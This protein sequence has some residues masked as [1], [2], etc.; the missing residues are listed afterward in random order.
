[1]K[2][3]IFLFFFAPLLCFAQYDFDSRYFTIDENSLPASEA[4]SGFKKESEIISRFSL[5]A[6]PVVV[7]EKLPSFKITTNNYRKPV[8]MAVAINELN[9]FAV[10]S[11]ITPIKAKTYGFTGYSGY[12][13]DKSSGVTNIVY[14]EQRGL[15]FVDACPPF[16]LCPRC[17]HYRVGRGY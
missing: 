11:E 1:M 9:S 12:S 17:A 7:D 5:D 2:N 14:K 15:N 13:A 4:F 8:E 3:W 16:G 6:A 10:V